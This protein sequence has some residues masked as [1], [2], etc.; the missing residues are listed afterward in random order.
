MKCFYSA[1]DAVGI[2]KSCGR[3][4]SL[5]FA[6]EFP[7]GLACKGRCE[8]AVLDLI[9]QQTAAASALRS[10]NTTLLASGALSVFAGCG[11]LYF[12]RYNTGLNLFDFMGGTFITYGLYAIIRALRLQPSVRGGKS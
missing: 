4:L 1:Q 11:F 10:N 2:C 6:T 7:T 8:P 3:G 12:N 5:A 9:R